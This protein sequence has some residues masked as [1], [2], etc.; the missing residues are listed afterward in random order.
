MPCR[1]DLDLGG[2]LGFVID[3]VVTADEADALVRA[4][5]HFGFRDEA[6]GIAT[7]PGMRM[8]KAVHWVADEALMGPLMQRIGPLLPAEVDGAPLHGRFSHRLNLYRYDRNDV[9]NRHIDGDWPGYGLDPAPTGDGRVGR[10]ALAADDGAVP[11]RAGRGRRRRQHAVARP[12]TAAGWT[13]RR[14]RARRCSSAT[15][16]IPTSVVHIGDRVTGEVPKY[17]A[18]INV[19]YG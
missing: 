8:N 15:A 7:P 9:F 12:T 18:R 5:E 1:H 19:L 16:R 6:P 3:D 17:V 11:E 2:L 4:S 10:R 14:A 13:S